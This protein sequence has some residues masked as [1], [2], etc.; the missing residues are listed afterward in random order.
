MSKNKTILEWL[1][2]LPSGYKERAISQYDPNFRT[3]VPPKNIKDALLFFSD[4][5][6]TKEGGAF[7][8]QVFDHYFYNEEPPELPDEPKPKTKETIL[9]WLEELPEG[10][11]QRAISQ[12]DPSFCLNHSRSDTFSDKPTSLA[13]A[14]LSFCNWQNTKEGGYFWDK[15]YLHYTCG[16]KLPELPNQPLDKNQKISDNKT[17]NIKELRKNGHKVRVCHYRRFRHPNR[18]EDFLFP[19][20]KNTKNI[21]DF[22]GMLDNNGGLTTV[23]VTSPE[24]KTVI[25][26]A[27]CHNTDVFNY[28]RGVEIA[29]SRAFAKRKS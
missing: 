4:W 8:H 14:V 22:V 15:V 17:M 9:D 23:E 27:K 28:K 6:D 11:R 1:Q 26:H 21:P 29:L 25:G 12:Y 13:Q 3:D 18:E 2:E 10:Y 16:E 5:S 7:W 20:S 24:G 19:Y